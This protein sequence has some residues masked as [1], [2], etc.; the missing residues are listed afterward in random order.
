VRRVDGTEANCEHGL[1]LEEGSGEFSPS[2][3]RCRGR[4]QHVTALRQ[5]AANGEPV[6]R[7]KAE[8]GLQVFEFPRGLVQY[9]GPNEQ[10]TADPQP[11]G[12]TKF[13]MPA[14]RLSDLAALSKR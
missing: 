11:I 5:R 3:T 1:P 4:L 14:Y 13:G 9:G 6:E 8:L 7:A 10:P 2:C 12:Y